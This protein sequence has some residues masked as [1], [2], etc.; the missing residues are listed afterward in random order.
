MRSRKQEVL[1]KVRLKITAGDFK[2]GT[3]FSENEL[4]SLLAVSR[5]PI[6]DALAALVS[7]GLIEQIPQV[8]VRVRV[9][10]EEDLRELFK[11][12]E[13]I[14]VFAATRLAEQVKNGV[15]VD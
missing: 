2:P 1:D 5:T 12:R 9:F 8:G 4:A 3:M 13:L 6:R 15:D 14:E 11:V 7:E 10:T